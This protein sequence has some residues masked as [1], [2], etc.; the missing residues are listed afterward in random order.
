M[1]CASAPTLLALAEMATIFEICS[2][3]QQQMSISRQSSAL[4]SLSGE[5]A[6]R[7]EVSLMGVETET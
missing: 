2:R 4:A 6:A 5:I 7:K 3:K 1:V